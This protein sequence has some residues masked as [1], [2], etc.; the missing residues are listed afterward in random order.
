MSRSNATM[1]SRPELLQDC[2]D[3]DEA[4]TAIGVVRKTLAEVRRQGRG[5]GAIH[6]RPTL[7][8]QK[9]VDRRV[10]REARTGAARPRAAHR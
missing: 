1:T 2:Y 7:V 10:D 5:T 4:A 8:V 3:I 9:I 6:D